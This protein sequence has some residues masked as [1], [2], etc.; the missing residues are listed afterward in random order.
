MRPSTKARPPSSPAQASGGAATY[1]WRFGGSRSSTIRPASPALTDTL[2]INAAT[3]GDA[4]Q[5]DAVATA[6]CGTPR[7]TP[8]RPRPPL[9]LGIPCSPPAFDQDGGVDRWRRRG[10]FFAWEAAD[11]SADVDQDGGIDGGDIEVFYDAWI[12]GG[13]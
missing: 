11:P 13:C 3:P 9:N 6:S 8:R 12:A 4:G 5:Y 1:Q 7:A 2:T 10:F